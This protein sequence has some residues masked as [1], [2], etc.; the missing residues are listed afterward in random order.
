MTKN[1]LFITTVLFDKPSTGGEVATNFFT[2]WLSNN[3]KI[4]VLGYSRDSDGGAVK[5]SVVDSIS[6]ET[7]FRN[8]FFI[9][10][11]L[12]AIF[13]NMPYSSYKFFSKKYLELIKEKIEKNSYDYIVVEHAQ[14]AWVLKYLDLGNCVF[15]SHNDESKLYEE[16]AENSGSFFKKLIYKRESRLIKKIERLA[17]NR[18]LCT[19]V[20]TESDRDSYA[21]NYGNEGKIKQV[22]LPIPELDR[23]KYRECNILYD[24]VMLGSWSWDANRSG[25]LWFLDKVYPRLDKNVKI[26][27]AGR[28]F[29][30]DFFNQYEN[31]EYV[32]FVES[33]TEF[34]LSGKCI[35]IPS[36]EGS[37]I[38][39]KTLEAISLGKPVVLTNKAVRG[40]DELPSNLFV[41]DD[42]I[43]FSN[44]I[45][46][47]HH[48]SLTIKDLKWIND[49]NI[50]FDKQMGDIFIFGE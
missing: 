26:G 16:I 1:I 45:N 27:I 19:V 41:T 18:S 20:L 24:V 13:C 28:G 43:D 34:L 48:K 10:K 9:K 50:K 3:F 6:I 11:F 44:S 35:A 4:D 8:F 15:I 29:E 33:S 31:I 36:I 22:N 47:N 39:I 37:G 38:Q 5:G 21:I 46:E 40:I 17:I 42:P 49:R 25:L 30:K 14:M 12:M 2:E 23:D 7:N 32:G